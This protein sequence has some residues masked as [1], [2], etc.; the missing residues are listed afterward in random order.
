MEV[1][2]TLKSGLL[3]ILYK[4]ALEYEFTRKNIFFER[5]KEYSVPYKDTILPHK[6]YADF[7]VENEIILE[8]KS[9]TK[10]FIE[11]D[12]AQCLNY[13]RLSNNRL[14]ILVNFGGSSLAYKRIVV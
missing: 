1:H 9:R 14:C 3:E 7:V 13:L 6:F 10:G 11:A 12:F 2:R 8:V 5:E 4:D